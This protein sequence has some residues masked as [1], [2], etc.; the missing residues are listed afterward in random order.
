MCR[1]LMMGVLA[2]GVVLI[3]APFAIGLPGKSADGE[4]MIQAFAPIMEEENVQTTVDYYYDVF[5]PL[6]GVVPAMS[7]E[8]I[9]TFNA[10]LEGFG[11]LAA[12]AELLVPALAEATG[13]TPEQA[14][15]YVASEFPAMAQMLQALPQMQ[16]DFTNLLGLMAAN[17]AVFEQVPGGLEHYEPLVTTMQEQRTNYESVASLPDFRAFTWMFVVPGALLVALALFGLV[18]S[19][20]EQDGAQARS[21]TT[22]PTEVLDD[23]H[24]AEPVA[25]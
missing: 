9:D 19:G 18:R 3:A 22:V 7:Q 23:E 21:T 12:D 17:V 1:K 16:E 11:G 5:V 14:G 24:V 20:R 2:I 8:N 4:Q 6:G 15:E 13:M 10:Y 25:H